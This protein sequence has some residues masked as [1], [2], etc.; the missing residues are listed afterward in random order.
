MTKFSQPAYPSTPAAF[1]PSTGNFAVLPLTVISKM[2]LSVPAAAGIAHGD[3]VVEHLHG[4]AGDVARGRL[5]GGR[6]RNAGVGKLLQI[7]VNV[8][9]PFGLAEGDL[10]F[11]AG[12]VSS[13]GSNVT[14]VGTG[15][16]RFS[17]SRL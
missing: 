4:H 8:V 16:A 13:T 1:G 5:S 9:V 17:I 7:D 6:N 3:A 11:R 14:S 12:P 15:A 2:L 10:V